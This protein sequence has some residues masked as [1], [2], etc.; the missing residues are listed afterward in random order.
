MT[1][2]NSAGEGVNSLRF[3]YLVM[4]PMRSVLLYGLLLV[5]LTSCL[6]KKKEVAVLPV[7]DEQQLIQADMAFSALSEARGMKN[8]FIEYMDSNGILLRPQHF[9][10]LEAEA[11]DFLISQDDAA[12][13]LTWKP[14][15]AVIASSGDLGFTYG[16]YALQPKDQDTVLYGSYVNIWKRQE[17]GSWKF[18]LNSGNDGIN[19]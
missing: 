12:F 3:F 9:P 11:I 13:T 19:P 7:A 4:I 15:N 17:D 14:K 8:A 18:I 1:K 2:N 10:I 6:F 5:F 16:L